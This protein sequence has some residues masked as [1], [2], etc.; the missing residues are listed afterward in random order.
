MSTRQS[1]LIEIIDCLASDEWF[2]KA[3][4]ICQGAGWYFGNRS[5][6]EHDIP[7]WKMDLGGSPVFDAIW[8]AAKPHCEKLAGRKLRVVRQYANGHTYGLG[9]QPHRDDMRDGTF[10]L[11]YYPMAEWKPEWQGETV[12]HDEV[13][14]E[15]ELSVS[16]RPNRA[17]FFDARIPHAG[18]APSR[19]CPALRVTVAYKLEPADDDATAPVSPVSITRQENNGQLRVY[20]ILA[21]HA[22]I[23]VLVDARL[24]ELARTLRVPGYRPG[25]IPM[26]FLNA[27][28]GARTRAEAMQRIGV[29][30][31]DLL[32]AKGCLPVSLRLIHGAD[33]GDAEFLLEV[34]HLPDLPDAG[35]ESWKLERLTAS[36]D[37]SKDAGL[38]ETETA[39][40]LEGHLRMQALDR[41]DQVYQFPVAP[42][43]VERELESIRRT[44]APE[45]PE[46]LPELR[47]IAQR[48]VK[49][50]V[51]IIE[52]A[53]RHGIA[54][55]ENGATLEL[56]VVEWLLARASI[57]ERDLSSVELAEMAR[58]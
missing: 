5:N 44:M 56:K 19:S 47:E 6:D 53:R 31:A 29:N 16:P 48:R 9:G 21:D 46:S 4:E 2:A 7:F 1:D 13:T 51:V 32:L 8:Q 39:E 37:A 50:G 14:G 41:L 43:L 15:I 52:L 38:G 10:T 3:C 36:S 23:T 24:A 18:R 45:M 20:S 55:E 17:V 42:P 28:Y 12:F 27:R 35:S 11:L 40:L 22:H 57:T 34:I 26:D 30:A 58:G 54:N 25:K 49:L 33:S